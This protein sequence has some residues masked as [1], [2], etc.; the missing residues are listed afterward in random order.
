MI[1]TRVVPMLICFAFFACFVNAQKKKPSF[2][3]FIT[4]EG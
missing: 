1:A 4:Y 2:G 3:P